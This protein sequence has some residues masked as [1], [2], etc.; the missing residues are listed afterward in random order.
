MKLLCNTEQISAPSIKMS[1]RSESVDIG[2]DTEK[3]KQNKTQ[4]S[5]KNIF[6]LKRAGM[7]ISFNESEDLT[8]E[9]MK[10]FSE[11]QNK[12]L[13]ATHRYSHWE[14]YKDNF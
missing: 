8:V 4:C 2:T 11:P 6:I 14:A 10:P 12:K 9:L 5:L 13:N 3:A 7:S 1:L